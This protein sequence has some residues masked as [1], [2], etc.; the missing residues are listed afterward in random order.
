MGG[1]ANGAGRDACYQNFL[2]MIALL[3]VG[4]G[5]AAEPETVPEQA[6]YA[7][8]DGSAAMTWFLV[9]SFPVALSGCRNKTRM[10]RILGP[11]QR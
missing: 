4:N 5:D 3:P 2:E 11:H 10:I 1:L 7:L 8:F 6:G 9:L